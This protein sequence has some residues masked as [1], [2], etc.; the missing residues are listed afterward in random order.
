[1]RWSAYCNKILAE[2]DNEAFFL[3]ELKNVQRRGTE[4]KA[5]CPFKELHESATDN[6]PSLTVNIVNGVF[7]CQ[8]CHSK[9]NAQTLY[10]SLYKLSSE[11]A[12]FGLGD[13]LK[14]DRPDSTRPAR[15]DIDDG[16]A[17]IYNQALMKLTGPI[18]TVLSD[19]RGLVDESLR[20]FQLGWDGDRITIPVYDEYNNIVNFRKYKWN[21]DEDQWKALNYIDE[22]GNAY[23]EVRIYGIDNLINDAIEEIVWCEGELD[24]VCAEQHGFPTACPTSGA[25]SWR[26]EWVKYFRNKKKVYVAQ[27]NDAA[28][29][30]ATA[31]ICSKL[32]RT[33][34]VYV[35][36]WPE[37]FPEKGDITDFFTKCKLSTTDFRSLLDSA[38]KY[39]DP[40]N[41]RVVVDEVDAV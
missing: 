22:F 34:D 18:R 32:W 23:G 26:P 17:G 24:R 38:T 6:T 28:G 20:K 14:I 25:G 36:N 8:T 11:E 33:V 5:E 4:L 19:R 13:G 37:N 10:K 30:I 15:P 31:K 35:V 27:D 12:W 9:G 16:L 29:R 7:Y 39:V 3:S 2:L 40:H 21:S 1:M 41:N